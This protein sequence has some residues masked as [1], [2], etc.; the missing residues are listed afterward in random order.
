[1]SP[2]TIV[3]IAIAGELL[4]LIYRFVIWAEDPTELF[5]ERI[6]EQLSEINHKLGEVISLLKAKK[7]SRESKR[8]VQLSGQ[9]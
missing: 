9:S 2:V 6:S 3:L 5:V 8:L 1:M 4:L 7:M